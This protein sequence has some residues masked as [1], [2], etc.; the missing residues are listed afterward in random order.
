MRDVRRKDDLKKMNERLTEH[1]GKDL[2]RTYQVRLLRSN[3]CSCITLQTWSFV[4]VIYAGHGVKS[5]I[6]MSNDL[7]L[8]WVMVADL[9]DTWSNYFCKDVCYRYW[10]SI[11]R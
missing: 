4:K 6:Y 1:R 10:Q 5:A 8:M 3:N 2:Q 7:S 9:K 11:C